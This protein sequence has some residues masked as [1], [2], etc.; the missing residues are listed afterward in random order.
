MQMSI[1][2]IRLKAKKKKKETPVIP[3]RGPIYRA[4]PLTRSRT[5]E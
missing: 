1:I 2:K 4:P 5:V 3:K